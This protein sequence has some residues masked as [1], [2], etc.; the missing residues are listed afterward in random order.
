MVQATPLPSPQHVAP[1]AHS[2]IIFFV[3]MSEGA[4]P[5]VPAIGQRMETCNGV[6]LQRMARSIRR[7]YL[8]ENGGHGAPVLGR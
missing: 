2:F 8:Q 3:E 6:G 1:M 5:E 4:G 7:W